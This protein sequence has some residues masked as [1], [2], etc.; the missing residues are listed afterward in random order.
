LDRRS[1]E[2]PDL[3]SFV[4]ADR[5]GDALKPDNDPDF[6]LKGKPGEFAAAIGLRS[7][8]RFDYPIVHAFK[9]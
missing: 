1:V 8:Y 2:L 3:S 4:F 7:E 6:F 5:G 9:P